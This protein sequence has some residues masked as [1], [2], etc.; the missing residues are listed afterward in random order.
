MAVRCVDRAQHEPQMRRY[1]GSR[2]MLR[3]PRV[4]DTCPRRRDCEGGAEDGIVDD[5]LIGEAAE[6]PLDLLLPRH[7]ASTFREAVGQGLGPPLA[8]VRATASTSRFFVVRREAEELTAHV[9]LRAA[10]SVTVMVNGVRTDVLQAED[11]WK[12]F[13]IRLALGKGRN[14]DR[15]GLARTAGG[16]R[17]DVRARG[18]TARTGLYPDALAAFGEVYAFTAG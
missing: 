5:L 11:R 10:G 1:L 6:T 12:T 16:R 8:F 13:V 3:A 9:T 17:G 4:A 2:E 14:T 15:P 7:R 18:A